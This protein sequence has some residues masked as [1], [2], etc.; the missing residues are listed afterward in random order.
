MARY[1]YFNSGSYQKTPVAVIADGF[2]RERMGRASTQCA[3]GHLS[4]ARVYMPPFKGESFEANLVARL[5]P[6]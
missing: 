4:D 1:L 6:R 3:L 2:L 5:D